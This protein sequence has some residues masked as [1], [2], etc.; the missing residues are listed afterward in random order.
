LAVTF[1]PLIYALFPSDIT[2]VLHVIKQVLILLCALTIVI[3]PFT[4][5]SPFRLKKFRNECIYKL[6]GK[7]RIISDR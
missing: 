1:L 2:G 3:I 4:K 5:Y 7:A 6:L